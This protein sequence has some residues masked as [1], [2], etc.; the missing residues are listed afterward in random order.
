MPTQGADPQ[1]SK[2]ILIL[3]VLSLV[4]LG[5][6]QSALVFLN[7]MKVLNNIAEFA[8]SFSMALARRI[9]QLMNA[10]VVIGAAIALSIPCCSHATTIYLNDNF[11]NDSATTQSLPGS[12]AWYDPNNS[13][14]LS[15]S[16]GQLQLNTASGNDGL[17]A[18]FSPTTVDLGIGDSLEVSFDF[19]L[20][21]TLVAQDRAFG[22]FLY[23]SGGNSLTNDTSN[24]NSTLFNGYTGYGITYDPDSTNPARYRT[25]ERNAT[26]NNLFSSTVNAPLGTPAASS[27]LAPGQTYAGS[28]TVTQSATSVSVTGDINGSL[29]S[30]SD[31][32]SSYTDFDTIAFFASSSDIPELTLENVEVMETSAAPEPSTFVLLALGLLLYLK[33]LA[34]RRVRQIGT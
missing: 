3:Y 11:S 2:F 23:D 28:L 10:E 6:P 14:G 26:S 21:G 31:S 12:A 33:M 29:I 24:F 25:V 32:L 7:Y 27:I 18:Y 15:A 16:T 1:N 9:N 8:R 4:N 17:L 22:V 13:T 20:S 34:S 19:T 30:N 5:S